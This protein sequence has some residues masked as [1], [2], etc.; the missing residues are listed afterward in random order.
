MNPRRPARSIRRASLQL[1]LDFSSSSGA[2]RV[3]ARQKLSAI[4]E[5][6]HDVGESVVVTDVAGEHH[7]RVPT[8]SGAASIGRNTDT[9]P[10]NS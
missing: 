5:Q 9:K 7:V 4:R 1:L 6:V 8:A 3:V 2:F 10:G